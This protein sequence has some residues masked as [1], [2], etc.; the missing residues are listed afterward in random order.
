MKED[1]RQNGKLPL[2]LPEAM[3]ER[4]ARGFNLSPEFVTVH[5]TGLATFTSASAPGLLHDEN[6]KEYQRQ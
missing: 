4:I 1:S 6:D 5:G 3:F 2:P